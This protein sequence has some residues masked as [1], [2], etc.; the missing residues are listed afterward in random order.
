MS[1]TVGDTVGVWNVDGGGTIVSVAASFSIKAVNKTALAIPLTWLS[2]KNDEIAAGIGV[3]TELRTY[4][5]L[6]DIRQDPQ[7]KELVDDDSIVISYS[8]IEL[9]KADSEI[10]LTELTEYGLND[11]YGFTTIDGKTG[12]NITGDVIATGDVQGDRLIGSSATVFGATLNG[13]VI[14]VDNSNGT[15]G[16]SAIYATSG[17]DGYGID[18]GITGAGIGQRILSSGTGVGLVI[19]G[20]GGGLAI[21]VDDG[22]V[23][24]AEDL[25]VGFDAE[26]GNDLDVLNDLFVDNDATISN[27]LIVTGNIY[28]QGTALSLK[29]API[30]HVTDTANPH[31]VTKSQVGLGNVDNTSDLNKPISTATQ[32]AL[33]AKLNLSGGTI[34]GT[35]TVNDDVTI[36][37][38]LIK[39]TNSSSITHTL[40]SNADVLLW[41]KADA[42]NITETHNPILRMTQ[43]GGGVI[44]DKG[45]CGDGSE[46]TGGTA[47]YSYWKTD[48]FGIDIAPADS[49]SL[50]VTSSAI[51]LYEDTTIDGDLD[52][53]GMVFKGALSAAPGSASAGWVYYD[54]TSNKHRGYDGASWNDF[55]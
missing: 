51:T 17:G 37:G 47:N 31:S 5:P 4:N 21:R 8:G 32:T 24:L 34:T 12:G 54:T 11:K 48:T 3:E 30:A 2:A 35:L 28:E 6:Q 42:D 45:I 44:D 19:D 23:D 1:F 33:D 38:T 29:Y 55:Y 36:K 39:Q 49:R 7:L 9:S 18:I 52:Q 25:I 41:L 14:R 53:D 40:E 27:E 22:D 20:S 26:I 13:G 10:V 43:D 15:T 46:Y 16:D 50:R